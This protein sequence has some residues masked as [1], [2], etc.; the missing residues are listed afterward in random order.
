MA[1]VV[2][3][4]FGVWLRSRGLSTIGM[5]ADEADW[6]IRA[7]TGTDTFIRPAGYMALARWLTTL[8]NDEFTLRLP[9]F[10]AAALHLPVLW[11]VLRRTVQP[12]VAVLALWVFAVH[13]VAVGM[14]R[15][16]KPYAI[17]ALLHT[18]LLALTLHALTS[19]K[20]W[21][22][23]AVAVLSPL[24]PL[25]SWSV[26]F[27]YPGVFLTSLWQRFRHRRLI[28]VAVL[29]VSAL[30][31]LG[32]LVAL[33]VARVGNADRKAD[34]WG[35]KYD[36]FFTGESVVDH[37]IWVVEKAAALGGQPG[38]LLWPL[39]WTINVTSTIAAVGCVLG[40]LRLLQR[41]RFSLLLLLLLP[42]LTT[43]AFN[44]ARQWPWGVF[45][46]NF[47]LLPTVLVLAAIGVDTV[48]RAVTHRSRRV[49]DAAVLG[50]VVV[51]IACTPTEVSGLRNKGASSQTGQSDV[52]GA[53]TLLA[54]TPTS[55][56]QQ[57]LVLDGHGCSLFNYYRDHHAET[58]T[59]LGPRLHERVVARCAHQGPKA[60]KQQLSALPAQPFW[61]LVAQR[62]LQ[63]RTLP[64]LHAWC[65]LDVQKK[66]GTTLLV[67]CQP[68]PRGAVEPVEPGA[69]EREAA[70]AAPVEP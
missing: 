5:W 25:L 60:W 54:A 2:V 31:T 42:P 55:P 41:R 61:M 37:A 47:F 18:T 17:E 33:V 11:W 24:A 30:T 32:V 50:A 7:A 62:R 53:L 70:D 38:N 8:H 23:I 45:R 65:D 22:T 19:S 56:A 40:V 66:L 35:R 46:T 15:E 68:K 4:V 57:P 58:S 6:A 12:A 26:V 14:A 43:L 48:L 69:V 27:A 3:V 51:V 64:V 36:V 9:S 67:H 59:T 29:V 10:L 13:P 16:F 52:R 49:A 28:D 20:R 21:S 1:A 63:N 44:L 39:P 34:Y